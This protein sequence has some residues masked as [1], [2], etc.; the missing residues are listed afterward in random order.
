MKEKTSLFS[1]LWAL[2]FS[3]SFASS[4][5]Y[6]S[7]NAVSVRIALILIGFNAVLFGT[8]T[9]KFIQSIKLLDEVQIRIQLEAVS[10][11]FTLSLLFVMILGM[12]E[13]VKDLGLNSL[14]YL[15][16]FP[17]L[18]LFYIIGLFISKRKYR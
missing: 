14:S 6:L 1:V 15:Y 7:K 17:L 8:Y 11:A 5:Y 9:V 10:I 12:A 16:F 13:L 4:V 2:I 3:I 18:F